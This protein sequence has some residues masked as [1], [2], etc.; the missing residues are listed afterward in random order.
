LQTD[1]IPELGSKDLDVSAPM[2][3]EPPYTPRGRT[4]PSTGEQQVLISPLL[5][6]ARHDST[7]GWIAHVLF[8]ALSGQF[9]LLTAAVPRIADKM[10]V[11]VIDNILL[12]FTGSTVLRLGLLWERV[13]L[14]Y[15]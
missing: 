8:T 13:I 15:S 2:T 1:S 9:Q 4:K 5:L 14:S 11:L 7:L 6:E 12:V 3:S 10:E